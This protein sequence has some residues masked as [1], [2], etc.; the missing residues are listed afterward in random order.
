LSSL[1]LV[2]GNLIADVLQL[3]VDPR[4]RTGGLDAR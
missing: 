2:G 1:F 4:I 3:A